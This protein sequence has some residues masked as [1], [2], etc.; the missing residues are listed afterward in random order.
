MDEHTRLIQGV[1]DE[2]AEQN[3]VPPEHVPIVTIESA[4]RS[5]SIHC[6]CGWVGSIEDGQSHE[7][8]MRRVCHVERVG[9]PS[10][11]FATLPT[12]TE[13]VEWPGEADRLLL[14]LVARDPF[15]EWSN[16]DGVTCWHCGARRGGCVSGCPHS[17][18][19]HYISYSGLRGLP[20]VTP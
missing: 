14:A 16:G 13:A 15:G 12:A 7:C 8:N 9:E 6:A 11:A 2:W 10:L 1:V 19:Q 5:T 3:G 20:P 4:P 17:D 18:A